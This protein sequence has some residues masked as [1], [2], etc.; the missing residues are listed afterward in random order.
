[1]L[2]YMN[3]YECNAS[4]DLGKHCLFPNSYI[5]IFVCLTNRKK[6]MV[7]CMLLKTRMIKKLKKVPVLGF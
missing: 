5:I 3:W 1:M 4:L 7:F 2:F 6:K